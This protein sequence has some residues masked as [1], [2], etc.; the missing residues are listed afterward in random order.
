MTIRRPPPPPGTLPRR[1]LGV[2]G[3]YFALDKFKLLQRY[4][5][6]RNAQQVSPEGGGMG[7]KV[8]AP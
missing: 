3:C 6:P 7:L 5:I 2:N 4:K 8:F 1:V